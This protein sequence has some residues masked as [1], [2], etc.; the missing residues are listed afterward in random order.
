MAELSDKRG[1]KKKT[2]EERESAGMGGAKLKRDILNDILKIGKL[3]SLDG[4]EGIFSGKYKG[5]I[6]EQ[7]K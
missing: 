6:S 3:L 2:G 7:S 1:K 5:S 4:R